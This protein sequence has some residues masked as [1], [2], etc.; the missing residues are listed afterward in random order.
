MDPRTLVQRILETHHAFSHR[1][2]PILDALFVRH[3]DP[4][5]RRAW[6]GLS[7]TFRDHMAKEEE[8][9]FPAILAGH[10]GLDA[11]IA[12]M[13]Q[14]HE[15]IRSYER[16]LRRLSRL[17]GADEGRLLAFLDDLAEHARTEDED[18]FPLAQSDG[19]SARW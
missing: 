10:S 13:V 1:E 4:A 16:D 5:L 15:E 8:V 14:E 11:P 2:L 19:V 3:S 18:L 9:L 17:A 6:L 12:V 7:S